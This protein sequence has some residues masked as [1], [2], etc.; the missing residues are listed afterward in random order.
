M[1]GGD[2]QRLKQAL[3]DVADVPVSC[4]PAVEIAERAVELEQLATQ[5]EAIRCATLAAASDA[6]DAPGAFKALGHRHAIG[7]ISD[8][9][10]GNAR[11]LRRLIG[12]D[13]G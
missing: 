6:T 3:S 13:G 2:L 11:S 5:L 9:T 8:E 1:I 4:L 7:F 12:L 10:R